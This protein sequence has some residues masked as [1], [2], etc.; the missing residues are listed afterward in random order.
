VLLE[1]IELFRVPGGNEKIFCCSTGQVR[2]QVD[3]ATFDVLG[4]IIQPIVG[5]QP[6]KQSERSVAGAH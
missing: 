4:K 6:S 3:V 5:E 2:L 1:I